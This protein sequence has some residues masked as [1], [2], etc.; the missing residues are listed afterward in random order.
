MIEQDPLK[1]Y[2]QLFEQPITLTRI[3]RG[4]Q[5]SKENNKPKASLY[6]TESSIND[7]NTLTDVKPE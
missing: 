4:N 5:Q 2:D 1:F 7:K 6:D 3:S